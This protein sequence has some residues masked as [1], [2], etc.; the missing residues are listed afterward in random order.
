[1]KT[2]NFNIDNISGKLIHESMEKVLRK[3]NAEKFIDGL[4][5]KFTDK[6]R[7]K[8]IEVLCDYEKFLD[9]Q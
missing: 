8:F 3:R 1:M 2:T 9:A 6:Q 4:S 5:T 7:E